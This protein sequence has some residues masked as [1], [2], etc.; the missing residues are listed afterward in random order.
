MK[1]LHL[2]GGSLNPPQADW[3]WLVAID[4]PHPDPDALVRIGM[5]LPH[6]RWNVTGTTTSGIGGCVGDGERA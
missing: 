1:L 2:P 5:R 6:L 4:H 3:R